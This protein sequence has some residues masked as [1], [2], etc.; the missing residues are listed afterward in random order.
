M[1]SI[2]KLIFALFI[3]LLAGEVIA[4]AFKITQGPWHEHAYRGFH[5]VQMVVAIVISFMI[6][7]ELLKINEPACL[8]VSAWRRVALLVPLGLIFSLAGDI[9]N[10]AIID[11]RFVLGPDIPQTLLSVPFFA[12]AHILYMIVFF[13]L[14]AR[15]DQKIKVGRRLAITAVATLVVVIP[16]WSALIP[17]DA[18]GLIKSLTLFYAVIVTSMMFSS[19]WV[20]HAWRGAGILVSMGGVLFWVSDGIIGYFLTRD[21]WAYANIVIWSTYFAAQLLIMRAP[22][23][24][25][26]KRDGLPAQESV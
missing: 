19:L 5:L 9:I 18:P 1:A 14:A 4:S 16:L 7:V 2:R 13:T 25:F 23:L 12:V 21:S 20:A 24:A 3:V 10:S 22:L 15:S 11:L 6:R 26:V 17:G 8:S